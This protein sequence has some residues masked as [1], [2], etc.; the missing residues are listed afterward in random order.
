MLIDISVKIESSEVINCTF[1][2]IC[3]IIMENPTAEKKI[4]NIIVRDIHPDVHNILVRE[5]ASEKEKRGINQYSLSSTIQK[6]VREWER[7]IGDNK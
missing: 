1:D 4:P 3:I 2:T 7:C 6:I 5:Q